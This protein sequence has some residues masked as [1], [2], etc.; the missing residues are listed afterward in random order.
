MSSRRAAATSPGCCRSRRQEL[1]PGKVQ[2]RAV[3]EIDV[4]QRP[5]PQGFFARR[6]EQRD[7]AQIAIGR[8]E[9]LKHDRFDLGPSALD[10]L[11][12]EDGQRLAALV[13]AAFHLL[14]AGR[15][16]GEIAEV[17]NGPQPGLLD[18]RKQLAPHPVLVLVAVRD[19]HV[20]VELG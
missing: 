8:V 5:D 14:D 15:P 6:L 1:A 11:R 13:Y 20:E 4:S 3:S 10:V 17:D 2:V 18:P 7:Q 9:R 12:R 19:E 16:A